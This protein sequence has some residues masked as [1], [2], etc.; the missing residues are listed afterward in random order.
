MRI[1][2]E[3]LASVDYYL[4]YYRDYRLEDMESQFETEMS[5][6]RRFVDLGPN[7]RMLEI[8]TGIGWLPL[9]CA[10]NGMSCKG[11]EISP[12]LVEYAHKLGERYGLNADITLGNIEEEEI[13]EQVYD[14]IFAESVFEHVENWKPAMAKIYKALKTGG[15]LSFN[16]TNKFAPRS[17]EYDYPLYGWMPNWMRYRL[18]IARQGPDIMK[19]GIDFHQF[20]YPGLR[21]EFTRL[22]FSRVFDRLD[23]LTPD[24]LLNPSAKKRALLRATKAFPPL[25]HVALAFVNTTNFICVK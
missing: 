14:V 1:H 8:G 25:K 9:L 22:G 20:T 3:Q 19:L 2:N 10:K 13:G 11:L 5:K 6:V 24:T 18:R 15:V 17:G 16:S 4:D 12:Q 23:L 7:T 21:R